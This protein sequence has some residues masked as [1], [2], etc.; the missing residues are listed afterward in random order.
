MKIVYTHTHGDPNRDPEIARVRY[1]SE[2]GDGPNTT[3]PTRQEFRHV[4][5]E[6]NII[7]TT[8]PIPIHR[9]VCQNTLRLTDDERPTQYG[10]SSTPS[11]TAGC[12][13][14]REAESHEG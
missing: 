9:P 13:P 2:P 6:G 1:V 14:L 12:S 8:G 10:V 11:S 5:A 3:H 4:D 7:S